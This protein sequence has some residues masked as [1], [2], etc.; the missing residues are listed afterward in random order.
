MAA[1][2]ES[3]AAA[4]PLGGVRSGADIDVWAAEVEA[5]PLLAIPA[6]P[7]LPVTVEAVLERV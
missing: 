3:D 4:S 6:D 2:G 5:L 1:E 7:V